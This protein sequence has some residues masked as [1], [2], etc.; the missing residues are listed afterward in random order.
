VGPHAH[1]N[2]VRVGSGWNNVRVG[3]SRSWTSSEAG[4]HN[5]AMP[6]FEYTC[7]GCGHRFEFL[8]REGKTPACP[9]CQGVELEKQLSVFAVSSGSGSLS[10][11]AD[12]PVGPCGSCGDPRG[13][14]ACS[15]N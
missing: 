11:A 5:D 14:G 4:C 10:F 1:G 12:R 3:G 9:S 6:L 7:R 15:L 8:T 13:P 2:G